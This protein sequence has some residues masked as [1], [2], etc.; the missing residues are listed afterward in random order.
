M[1]LILQNVIRASHRHA[2]MEE[3]AVIPQV[4]TRASARMVTLETTAIVSSIIITYI[5]LIYFHNLQCKY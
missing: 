5:V 1:L 4:A 2:R 3:F